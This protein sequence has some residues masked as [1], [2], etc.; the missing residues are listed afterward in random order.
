MVQAACATIEH[1]RITQ[2]LVLAAFI[3]KT[4]T[5]QLDNRI[6]LRIRIEIADH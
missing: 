4:V 3:D 2:T 5:G 6:F 1:V